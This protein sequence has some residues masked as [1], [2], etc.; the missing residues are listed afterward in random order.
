M[1]LTP[2]IG[3]V[4]IESAVTSASLV[5]SAIK[6]TLKATR[7]NAS[8][9]ETTNAMSPVTLK[10]LLAYPGLPSPIELPITTVTAS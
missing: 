8:E 10:N 3:I 1:N 6:G 2:K 9:V 5:N 7:K 4:L